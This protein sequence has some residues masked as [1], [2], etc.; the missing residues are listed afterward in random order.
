MEES[1]EWGEEGR[2]RA[3]DGV[4]KNQE[5]PEEMS[6]SGP[7]PTLLPRGISETL[8]VL[9]SASGTIALN[10]MHAPKKTWRDY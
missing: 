2:V 6:L 7:T 8:S 1:S 5:E 4:K 10:L 9:Q 3:A